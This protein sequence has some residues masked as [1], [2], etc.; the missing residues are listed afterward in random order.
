M[1]FLHPDR[2]FAPRRLP[3]FYGWWIAVVATLGVLMSIP[4]Q[5][6]GVSVFTDDLLKVTGLS[7]LGLSNTYL[8]GTI[9]A[10]LAPSSWKPRFA[11]P[12]RER[13]HS[14]R[15]CIRVVVN[16]RHDF[17]LIYFVSR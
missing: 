17:S 12:K 13:P 3:F 1:A 11:S 16:N 6:M 4:G 15:I 10:G 2:P 9:V 8:V 5:T 14:R 7:R